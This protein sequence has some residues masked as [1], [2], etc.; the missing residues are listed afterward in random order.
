MALNLGLWILMYPFTLNQNANCAKC[1]GKILSTYSYCN[2]CGN[3]LH[4]EQLWANATVICNK[5]K[6]RINM[7]AKFCPECGY[8]Q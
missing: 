6:N 4:P 7:S 3:M 2:S 5:C 1:G 8:K